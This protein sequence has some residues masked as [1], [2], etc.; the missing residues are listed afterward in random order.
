MVFC[1]PVMAHC[2]APNR[3]TRPRFM[4]IK[5]QIRIHEGRDS[6]QGNVIN[7]GGGGDAGA[8]RPHRPPPSPGQ[9]PR[10]QVTASMPR[11]RGSPGAGPRGR[12]LRPRLSPGSRPWLSPG[13]RPWLSPGSRPRLP[14][15]SRMPRAPRQ[16]P[17]G[18]AVITVAM[19]QRDGPMRLSATSRR[20]RARA[21]GRFRVAAG[22]GGA[23]GASVPDGNRGTRPPGGAPA[24]AALT[25]NRHGTAC[26]VPA[27]APGGSRDRT[28]PAPP[29]LRILS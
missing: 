22:A 26:P 15:R 14:P 25:G 2:A 27:G 20:L 24:P 1:H 18:G 7:G 28:R 9:P 10:S 16:C 12:D 5:A 6:G 8:R 23:G 29:S 4:R 11:G 13:S 21:P 19:W 3:G 17:G